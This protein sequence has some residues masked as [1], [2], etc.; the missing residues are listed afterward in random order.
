[1]KR[2]LVYIDADTILVSAAAKEEVT[3]CLATNI[4]NGKSKLFESKTEFNKWIK[5]NPD[6]DKTNYSF[7]GV[8]EILEEELNAHGEPIPRFAFCCSTV[9]KKIEAIKQATDAEE[10][11][12]LIQG[13]GNFRKDYS[14]KFV[15]YKGQRVPKPLML[16]ELQKWTKKYYKD[17]CL[18]ISGEEVDDFIVRKGWESFNRSTSVF[19]AETIIAFC[20]KDIPAN[21]CGALFNYLH[22]EDDVFWHSPFEQQKAFWMQN[23]QGDTAD[24]ID[25]IL[26]LHQDTRDKYGIKVAGV[27]P[28][29]AEKL[30]AG[31]KDEKELA[32]VVLEAYML[33]YPE[34]GFER[35][36]DMC[37]FLWMRRYE[38]QMF[39]LKEHLDRLGVN[40]VSN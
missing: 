23:L 12:V 25:G 36:Q 39:S 7:E 30:L 28:K 19:D 21:T 35:L 32:E 16:E 3:R 1:M 37:F 14:S 8:K 22:A 18:V 4:T 24:N 9:K 17:K 26:K 40:Y 13:K 31:C 27:G 5:D 6:K 20:D 2:K 33:S 29:T 11:I 15:N 10:A 34:D 38:G